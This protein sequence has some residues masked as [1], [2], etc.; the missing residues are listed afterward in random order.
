MVSPASA[1]V[2]SSPVEQMRKNKGV[3]ATAVAVIVPVLFKTPAATP[4]PSQLI[5]VALNNIGLVPVLIAVS[6][7]AGTPLPP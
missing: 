1:A 7:V 4:A 5:P 3:P 6:G 2:P